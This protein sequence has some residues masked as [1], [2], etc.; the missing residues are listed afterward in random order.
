M[1]FKKFRLEHVII[2]LVILVAVIVLV[3][4]RV[5]VPIKKGNVTITTDKLEYIHGENI[6]ITIKNNLN[7]PVIFYYAGIQGFVD[8]EWQ[9][10]DGD[11][12]CECLTLCKAAEI[13]LLPSQTKQYIWNQEIC[14]NLNFTKF[15]VNVIVVRSRR[16]SVLFTF[17]SNE[18]R[19]TG[20]PITVKHSAGATIL[21]EECANKS[22][23]EE[24]SDYIIEGTVEQVETK[25]NEEKTS[26]FTYIDLS[27]G[28]YVK[29]VPLE[30]GKIEII[31]DGGCVDKIC[32]AIEDT[33]ILHEGKNIRIYFKKID[34][35]YSI[36]CEQSGIKEIS[37][38]WQS[39]QIIN[40]FKTL[41]KGMSYNEVIGIVGEPDE[42]TGSGLWIAVYNLPDGSKVFSAFP[43]PRGGTPIYIKHGMLNGTFVDII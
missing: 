18:F 23:I 12:E 15:K 4:W 13:S 10:V 32:Q 26:I 21:S 5:E 24:N 16:D 22:Y 3:S 30:T 6:T 29:G 38:E 39:E 9:T 14:Q 28:K 2:V 41:K 20:E 7:H 27:I 40:N 1:K 33:P 36:V 35:K 43:S 42:I 34:E 25:W 37:I 11:V 31:T 8:N 19:L 17:N